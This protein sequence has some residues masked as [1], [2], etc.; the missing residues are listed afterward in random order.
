MPRTWHVVLPPEAALSEISG[1]VADALSLLRNA[2]VI[3]SLLDSVWKAIIKA[4]VI[5]VFL[6]SYI[7]HS[8]TWFKRNV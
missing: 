6:L 2:G 5:F 1:A 3:F 8:D 7:Q 4:D